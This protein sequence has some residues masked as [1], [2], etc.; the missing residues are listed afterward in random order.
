MPYGKGTYGNVRGRPKKTVK[1]N[2]RTAKNNR[3]NGKGGGKKTRY[4]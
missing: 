4:A 2:V 3:S 1:K